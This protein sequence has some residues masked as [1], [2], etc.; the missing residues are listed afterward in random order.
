M[1]KIGERMKTMIRNWLDIQ[2][3]PITSV[4]LTE[5]MPFPLKAIESLIWYRGDAS[6]LDQFYKQTANNS[7]I[8][9]HF[10][11][12]ATGRSTRKI[13]SGLPAIMVD[14]LSYL[15]KTDLD[16]VEF[17]DNV[18]TEKWEKICADE[19]FDFSDIVGRGVTGAL[20]SGDGAWKISIDKSVSQVPIV[21]FY[22]AD[23]V[24]YD[25]KHGIICGIDFITDIPHKG[26]VLKIREKYRKGKVNYELYDND[27]LL[28]AEKLKEITG[29]DDVSFSDFYMAVPFKIYDN[30]QY[31]NRGK[32][33]LYDK[34]DDFDAFDEL[35]SQ[36]MDAYRQ[37]RTQKYIPENLIP[38]D[39]FNGS[40][41]PH[42][43]FDNEYISV[44]QSM[45]ENGVVSD[46]IQ[47]V[48]P[49]IPYEA[50]MSGYTHYLDLC[51]QG[52]MSPA[53]LG[54]DLGKM[55]SAD[56]QREKKDITGYTRNTITGKLEKVL[57]KLISSIMMT[58]D[59][60]TGNA[61]QSYKPKVIFGEYGAPDFD[62]RVN[63]V[64]LAASN[65]IM[66][67]ETQVTELWGSSKDEEWI[68]AEIRRIKNEKG[69]ETV[70]EPKVGESFDG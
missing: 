57:P 43:P 52:I 5:Q 28:S 31:K 51:L 19:N 2:P 11:S 64:G 1:S 35:I 9:T 47:V 30:P 55:A 27:R 14:T 29:L 24:E 16:K 60:M 58:Y 63:T 69:I 49:Q 59:V 66:S 15:V 61:V 44:E 54:I 6:E 42:N 45:S 23:R 65:S 37:G 3:A 48:Q 40:L 8:A 21:E 56:A 38:R 10:W 39:Q 25:I 46:K 4:S 50:F 62:S 7:V 70:D 26:K 34:I 32:S 67:I 53:T 22:S 12:A 18:E 33:I 41:K 68:S 36:W 13:H 20:S 17:T